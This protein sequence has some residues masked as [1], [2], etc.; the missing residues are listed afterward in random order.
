LV[1]GHKT[2]LLKGNAENLSPLAAAQRYYTYAQEQLSA[3]AAADP[4]G[5]LALYALGRAAL[6]PSNQHAAS[7]QSTA[8]AMALYQAALMADSKNFRAANELGV[9]MAGQGNLPQ[10]RDLF[11]QSA[12]ASPQAATWYNL[13][14]VHLRMKEPQLAAQAKAQGDTLARAGRVGSNPLVHVVDTQTF[15]QT[16]PASDSVPPQA[17]AA[18]PAAPQPAKPGEKP[19]ATTAKKSFTDW[20]PWTTRR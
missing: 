4:A 7:L 20:L 12:A 9:L 2:P 8:Q 17:P 6:G 10:A 16:R 11:L 13:A 3:A 5:S 1:A 15:A 14:S 19:A 18:A